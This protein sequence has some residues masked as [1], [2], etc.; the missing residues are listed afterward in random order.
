MSEHG[1][2]CS[3]LSVNEAVDPSRNRISHSDPVQLNRAPLNS[4]GDVSWR[5]TAP[6]RV[7][8]GEILVK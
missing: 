5:R 1:L 4:V 7:L 8:P 2:V 6:S 3:A